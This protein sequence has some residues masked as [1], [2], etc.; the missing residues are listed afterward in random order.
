MEGIVQHVL[1]YKM[2]SYSNMKSLRGI[3]GQMF[4]HILGIAKVLK[5]PKSALPITCNIPCSLDL[6]MID[7]L[8]MLEA[9]TRKIG[10]GNKSV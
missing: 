5:M 9:R 6:A 10:T 8:S 1:S 4:Q 2:C 7:L 3:S